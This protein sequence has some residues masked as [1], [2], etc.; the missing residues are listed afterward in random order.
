LVAND[1]KG[2]HC[3]IVR[4]MYGK[5]VIEIMGMIAPLQVETS[6]ILQLSTSWAPH[7]RDTMLTAIQVWT[8][9]VATDQLV[10]IICMMLLV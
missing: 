10:I 8:R 5:S 9:C 2:F 1:R 7:V 4:C 3:K 6:Q